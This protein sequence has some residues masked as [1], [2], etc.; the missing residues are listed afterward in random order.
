MHKKNE[1]MTKEEVYMTEREEL[2][3]DRGGG[4]RTF[5]TFRQTGEQQREI[6]STKVK[7]APQLYITMYKEQFVSPGRVKRAELRPTS[8]HRRNNP[9][10]QP[11]R[12]KSLYSTHRVRHCMLLIKLS[13]RGE[14][15]IN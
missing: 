1:K 9:Q 3:A 12:C 4:R 10:P 8:A 7:M 6:N 15:S 14:H 5:M 2:P 11:V 13:Q